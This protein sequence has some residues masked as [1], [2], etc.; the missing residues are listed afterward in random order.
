M[1]THSTFKGLA[2]TAGCIGI[3]LANT[4]GAAEPARVMQVQPITVI[5]TI[6]PAPV[7]TAPPVALPK[8]DLPVM[9]R[10]VT[11]PPILPG[12]I[13]VQPVKAVAPHASLTP[14]APRTPLTPIGKVEQPAIPV[15][16]GH[17]GGALTELQKAGSKDAREDRRITRNGNDIALDARARKLKKDND[18]INSGMDESKEKA[19]NAMG[20]ADIGLATGIVSG[21]VQI[22]AG[23]APVDP[24]SEDVESLVQKT[25]LQSD[26]DNKAGLREQMEEIK[27]AN[28]RKQ[29]LR[30][31][32]KQSGGKESKVT[33]KGGKSTAADSV[34]TVD[35]ASPKMPQLSRP[36]T[37]INPC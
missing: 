26:K 5:K 22:G 24:E 14:V 29:A 9:S 1:I 18:S 35:V 21:T 32:G 7:V 19:A 6:Q 20:A 31:S 4:L 33:G 11:I 23:A 3:L 30:E 8:P 10:P 15:V 34:K 36:C 12:P 16:G 25:L 28:A 13:S 37:P 17:P 2:V 27:D